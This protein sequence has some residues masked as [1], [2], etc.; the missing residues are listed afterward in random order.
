MDGVE[1]RAIRER[2]AWTQNELAQR[3]GIHKRTVSRW[4]YGSYLVPPAMEVALRGLTR[5]SPKIKPRRRAGS[6]R[7]TPAAEETG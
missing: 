2:F 6:G 1:I 7:G 3:L 4:E 5:R